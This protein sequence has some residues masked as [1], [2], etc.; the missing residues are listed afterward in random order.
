[1][2]HGAEAW[3]PNPPPMTENLHDTRRNPRTYAHAQTHTRVHKH[4][5]ARAQSRA[6]CKTGTGGGPPVWRAALSQ[7]ASTDSSAT[8]TDRCPPPPPITAPRT[9]DSAHALAVHLIGFATTDGACSTRRRHMIIE[10]ATNRRIAAIVMRGWAVNVQRT[11]C[12]NSS[13]PLGKELCENF[14]QRT[15]NTIRWT[16]GRGSASRTHL[17]NAC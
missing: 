16:C 11:T 8:R 1:M 13:E 6:T 3:F 9:C 2:T 17:P 4:G 10:P 5:R 7:R 15:L 14:T 12:W